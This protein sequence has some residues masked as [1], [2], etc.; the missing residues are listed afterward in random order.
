MRKAKL[1]IL[2]QKW[3]QDEQQPSAD[4]HKINKSSM[5]I[6]VITP[7]YARLTQ[8]ADLIRLS[9]TLQLVND[10]HWIVIEVNLL[11]ICRQQVQV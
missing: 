3:A 5:I 1:E 10:I 2:K 6:Y 11:T 9:Q 8:K 4:N 7:T